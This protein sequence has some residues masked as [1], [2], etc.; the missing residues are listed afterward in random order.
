VTAV[1][2]LVSVGPISSMLEVASM[3]ESTG[4]MMPTTANR[5]AAAVSQY[6]PFRNNGANSQ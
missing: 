2:E 5:S 3:V 1:S 4:R 6:H